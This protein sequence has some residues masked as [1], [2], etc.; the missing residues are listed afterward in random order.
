[1]KTSRNKEEF[2][3]DFDDVV[4]E[5]K[6]K[7]DKIPDDVMSDFFALLFNSKQTKSSSRKKGVTAKELY[8]MPEEELRAE[9]NDYERGFT[10]G[11]RKGCHE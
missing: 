4:D 11:Y 9:E 6:K 2:F 8:N 10:D 1:M 5:M 7:I 3:D